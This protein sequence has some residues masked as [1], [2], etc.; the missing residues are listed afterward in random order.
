MACVNCSERGLECSERLLPRDDDTPR[1]AAAQEN[2][3]AEDIVWARVEQIRAEGFN[4]NDI[5]WMLNFGRQHS[6]LRSGG[7]Q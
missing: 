6:H 2:A 3:E 7:S 5:V 4:D 1:R